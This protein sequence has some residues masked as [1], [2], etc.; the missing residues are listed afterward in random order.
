MTMNGKNGIYP[1]TAFF[2]RDRN[3]LELLERTIH[4][5]YSNPGF[6]LQMLSTKMKVGGRQ[7]Q[8]RLKALL[9]CAPSEFLRDFRLE[10]S[11]RH[12]H[13]GTTIKEVA[14]AVGFSSQSYFA[15]CFK[16]EFGMTPSDYQRQAH[17]SINATN[18]SNSLFAAQESRDTQNFP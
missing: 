2:E 4:Q 13:L 11:L 17:F 16:A 8:R 3:F 15:S 9:G 18:A 1:K 10:Q 6:G 7:I 14:Q 5:N 12:L